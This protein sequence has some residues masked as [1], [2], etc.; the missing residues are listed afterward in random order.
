MLQWL[1]IKH[2]G[3]QKAVAFILLFNTFS[4]YYLGR[5]IITKAGY[6]FTTGSYENTLLEVSYPISIIVS[7]VIGSVILRKSSKNRVL[8]G[9]IIAGMV[10]S[11]LSVFPISS[12][13]IGALS[14]TI[15]LGA[16]LGIGLPACLDYFK[17]STP[18]GNRGKLGGIT[19]FGALV[20]VP[21]IYTLMSPADLWVAALTLVAWR[22]LALPFVLAAPKRE[23]QP[24]M[25]GLKSTSL[26]DVLQTRIFILYFAAWLMFSLV[27]FGSVIGTS[28][29]A[30]FGVLVRIVE[31]AF[32]GI[33]TL[34]GG[35]VSDLVGRKKVLIFGFVSLGV[36]Y[37]MV[38]LFSSFPA[39]W[40][41]Y[42]AVDGVA[43]GLLWVLFMIVLWGDIAQERSEKFYALGE[44]PFFLTEILS[45]LL[46]PYVA[47]NPASSIFS[48]AAL[49]LFL[50]VLPL[51][52]APETL[53]EKNIKERELKIYIAEA[54]KM[55]QKYP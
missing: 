20:C 4:W 33:A 26:R 7:A 39:A 47:A 29:V 37:A 5:L 1:R 49:F 55:E 11:F 13:L 36:A 9:W 38:G 18:I 54:K 53:P 10:A 51:L 46:V 50:A 44:I 28:N 35:I 23:D 31:P 41:F 22:S 25:A 27:D 45:V 24:E 15:A 52:F 21:L 30:Q 14:T 2:F 3:R 8:S 19:L 17:S 12:T 16:S 34:I 42:F 40:I 6:A 48:F 43:L 32:A